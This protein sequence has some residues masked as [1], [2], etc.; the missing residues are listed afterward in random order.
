M[1]K[2]LFWSA[3]IVAGVAMMLAVMVPSAQAV[4]SVVSLNGVSANK[5]GGGVTATWTAT[6]VVNATITANTDLTFGFRGNVPPEQGFD[7]SNATVAI[8]GASGSVQNRGNSPYM[9]SD[10]V[11]FRLNSN[12]STGS[13]TV[14]ITGVVNPQVAGLY[15]MGV[16]V[17]VPGSE[18]PGEE[19]Q[20]S[21]PIAVGNIAIMGRVKKPDGT[22][23]SGSSGVGVNLRTEDF[24]QN[25]GTGVDENGY[26]A[27]S[28]NSEQ[29]TIKTG[30]TYYLEAWPG[31]LQGVV[32]P[33]PVSVVYS[34]N[35]VTKNLTMVAAKKT[36]NVTVKYGNGNPVTNASVW[37][38][39]R[40]GGGGSGSDVD[41]S[42]KAAIS[43]AGGTWEL[44]VNPAHNPETGQQY[45][46]DWTYTQ[47]PQ[48]VQF[49]DDSST[50][51]K[52]LTF[53]VQ[54]TN[55][56]IKGFV[57]KPNGEPLEG[58]YVDIRAGQAGGSGTGINRQD[59]SFTANVMAG[60][61]KVMVWPDNMNPDLARFYSDEISVRVEENQTKTLNIVMKKKTSKIT[62]TVLDK[63]GNGVEGVW[64][65]TWK[66]HGEGWANTQSGAG[67]A[68]T[69]WVSA[70]EW[71]LGIDQGRSNSGTKYIAVDMEQIGVTV[72][73]NQTITGKII[74]VQQADAV[75]NVSMTDN[76]GK[77]VSNFFGW[78][79]CRK[80][81]GSYGPGS[82]FG[83]GVDRGTASI[84]LLGGFT[85]VCGTHMPPETNMSLNKEIEI[86]VGAGQTK[87]VSLQL[88]PNDSTISGWVKD[89]KGNLVTGV[90]AEVFAVEAGNWQWRPGKLNPDGSYNISVRGGADK[91]Y[92][93]GVHFWG[94]KEGDSPFVETNPEPDSAVA[95]PANS[96]I[97]K[98]ITVFKADTYISGKVV[99]PNGSPMA[100]V[101]VGADNFRQLEDKVKGDFE[102]G[103]VF[104]TGTETR[105]DGTFR[106]N[107]VSG[108][109]SI[110]SGLPPEFES[111]YMS[112]K[113][114]EVTVTSTKP[115]TGLLL[116]Y[117]K[118]DAFLTA[119]GEFADGSTPEFGFCHAWNEEGGH[120][121][122]EMFSGEARIPLT[123]GTWW[124]GCDTF[125]PETNKF[126][127]SNEAQITVAT[128]DDKAKTFTLEM[129]KFDIPEAFSTTF[130]ATQQNNFTLPDGTSVAIPAN[131]MGT[132]E[133]TYTLTATPSTN[134]IF[135]D[136]DKPLT[137]AWDFEVTKQG[138]SGSELV[139]SFNSNVTICMPLPAD[140][141]AEVGVSVDDIFPKFWNSN[142][143]AW[144]T[145]DT[146]VI[147][148]DQ[149]TACMQV[150][151]FTEFALTSG[152][153][154]GAAGA[155]GGPAYVVAT[156]SSEGGPQVT[157][158]DGDG[159]AILNFFA[160]ASTLRIG[161]QAVAGDLN[162]DGVN[163]IV[164]APGEGAGPQIRV[165]DLQGNVIDQFW[166][167]ASHIR[168]GVKLAVADVDGDGADEIIVTT[169]AGAGPQVRIFNGSGDVESQFWA[170]P[171]TFRG[172]VSMATGDIDGDGV[173]EIIVAPE[174][175]GG[176]QVRA[177]DYDGTVVTQ[178]MAYA[179]TVRGG[180]NVTTGDIDADGDVDIVVAPKAG[181]GPQVVMFDGEG[182]VLGRFFAYATTFRGGVNVAVGDISGNG[183]N[184]IVATPVS[185]AGPQV[186]VFNGLGDVVSQFWAYASTLRGDFTSIVADLD[187]DGTDDIITAPGAG[188]GPQV[189][190]FNYN[191][192][193]VSQFF[194]HH[195]GFRGGIDISSV[196]AF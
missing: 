174:S 115:A 48:S 67:G 17:R 181:L 101:W 187:Q 146:A 125:M 170:Y 24:S 185:E 20:A 123:A 31:N 89:Q 86:T 71:E 18:G 83:A 111:D 28:V 21:A 10:R 5:T 119:T 46:V 195:T 23:A 196:P 183:T 91:A 122:R 191:G 41:S 176:P 53:T 64:L 22:A 154:F 25:F 162:G 43:V 108:E 150:S 137:F 61:Y 78:A 16:E 85:Y 47:T 148:E 188:M 68:F 35:T 159:N 99:D 98:I 95:V 117:R 6:M 189:R 81:G 158:W 134:L 73:D 184:E 4:S 15:T 30:T 127:R 121:G 143:G 142:A 138:D 133:S 52:S 113:E 7:L 66:R 112:P 82:E 36:I 109:Y 190:A 155:V 26:F 110:H 163:E 37:A 175:A 90:E 3:G 116:K 141:M 75:V 54:K 62:G 130:T 65:N 44:N 39:K 13:K 92:M 56:K 178:F 27:F 79:Y 42:G 114:V 161:I 152:A 80:K 38:N 186:R 72:K 84:L 166:A 147:N 59:G 126:Y 14:T 11:N 136:S 45:D 49:K 87:S 139:E 60:D 149:G 135:T 50:E 128:G 177:F 104:H 63:N 120:S 34:G 124:V 29:G 165:F 93:V 172:G 192:D 182:N 8:T 106:M 19:I 168:T 57:K 193:V 58:G 51:A 144:Q 131:A 32:S 2:K 9:S 103:K 100:H 156:P 167:F 94:S 194:T 153:A 160:F 96:Q 164:V 173:M 132:D 33:D 179:E 12:L 129:A 118:A 140:Y 74:R 151:H 145:P 169:M 88:V 76:S 69:F 97:T 171:E 180:F 157:V 70:G 102:G 55:A 1:T 77:A 40:D 107:I 105:G